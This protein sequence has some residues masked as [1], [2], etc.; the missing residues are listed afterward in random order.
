MSEVLTN[1]LLL[2]MESKR[3]RLSAIRLCRGGVGGEQGGSG[4]A[5]RGRPEST[6]PPEPP[7]PSTSL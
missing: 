1:Q 5:G 4:P 2:Q 6:L 7:A 3:R